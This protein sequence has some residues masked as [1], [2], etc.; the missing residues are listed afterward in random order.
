MLVFNP[1]LSKKM[2]FR[3]ALPRIS[4]IQKAAVPTRILVISS[5]YFPGILSQ[6]TMGGNTRDV[7]K[8]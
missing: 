5:I 4:V 7:M 3:G 8:V 2:D 6:A 1:F